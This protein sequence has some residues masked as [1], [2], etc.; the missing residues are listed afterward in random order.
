M[1]CFNQCIPI[2]QFILLAFSGVSG[3]LFILSPLVLRL[4]L[5]RRVRKALPVDKVYNCPLDWYGGFLRAMGFG[6]A[7]VFDRA[8]NY[9]MRDY[10]NGFD[11]KAFANRFEKTISYIYVTSFIIFML[12]IMLTYVTDWFGIFEW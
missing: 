12:C 8:K 1:I 11:V 4:T 7:A 10:Y 5:D 3:I 9:G 6:I 2:A